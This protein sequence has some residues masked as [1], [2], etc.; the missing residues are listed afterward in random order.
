[1]S[2]L[3]LSRHFQ[4]KKCFQIY[5]QR[6]WSAII[7]CF[8][9]N[10]KCQCLMTAFCDNPNL[11]KRLVSRVFQTFHFILK[12]YLSISKK[13]SLKHSHEIIWYYF[14]TKKWYYIFIFLSFCCNSCENSFKVKKVIVF[15][16]LSWIEKFIQITILSSYFFK[17]DSLKAARG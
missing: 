16:S 7:F 3:S 10:W 2:T 9:F 12:S 17:N 6:F 1:M 5:S 11:S 4:R 8:L 15:V 14:G 13:N